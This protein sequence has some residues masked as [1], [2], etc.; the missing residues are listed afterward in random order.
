VRAITK[1]LVP[2]T[3]TGAEGVLLICLQLDGFGRCV[4]NARFFV[5]HF[6][7]LER[8]K[9]GVS[10]AEILSVFAAMIERERR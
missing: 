5:T 4:C 8:A 7:F 2:R 3:A 9:C 10:V 1:G 6:G